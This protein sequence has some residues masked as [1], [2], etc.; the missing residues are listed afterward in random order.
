MRLLVFVFLVFGLAAQ[1]QQKDDPLNKYFL[2]ISVRDSFER[3]FYFLQM[4]SSFGIDSIQRS[5]R[6]FS[7]LKTEMPFTEYKIQKVVVLLQK[8]IWQDSVT[9]E[10]YDTA[11]VV[12]VEYF[13]DKDGEKGRNDFYRRL[14]KEFIPF[15]AFNDERKLN[16]QYKAQNTRFT[17]GRFD[18]FA[19]LTIY[20]GYAKDRFH[21]V[22]LRYDKRRY[23]RV[24]EPEVFT[25][26]LSF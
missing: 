24:K 4:S 25:Q 11:S 7:S 23:Y 20:R 5:N 6:I 2:G 1:P 21:Y 18:N 13:F 8:Q 26:V 12:S 19:E 15:Y 10:H 3:S 16:G 14:R 9:K 17:Q 22:T